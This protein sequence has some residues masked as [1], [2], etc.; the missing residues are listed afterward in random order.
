MNRRQRGSNRRTTVH[1]FPKVTPDTIALISGLR[2]DIDEL[3]QKLLATQV[4]LVDLQDQLEAV[5]AVAIVAA[6]AAHDE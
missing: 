4:M 5:R 2:A 6:I 1:T 3:R